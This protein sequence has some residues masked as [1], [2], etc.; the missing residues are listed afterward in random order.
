MFKKSL[1]AALLVLITIV[2]MYFVAVYNNNKTVGVIEKS[3]LT[4]SL[5]RSIVWMHDNESELIK[6]A[7]PML[8]WMINEAYKLN[9]DAR[10]EKLLQAY[11]Q[12]HSMIRT[13]VWGPMFDGR[14]RTFINPSSLKHLPYYNKHLIYSLNCASDLDYEIPIVGE[15]NDSNFCF[16]PSYIYR[17]ACIT[18][19]LM[20]LNFVKQNSCLDVNEID[21]QIAVL[22]SAVINQLTW[23]I[24]VVDV[25]L[26]RVLVLLLIDQAE[27]VKP[28]WLRQVLNAQASDGGWD[29]FD[30]L[31]PL[32]ASSSIGF[33]AKAVSIASN[34]SNLHA[35][36]QG[37]YIMSK[38]IYK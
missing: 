5:E 30:A 10:I 35:T 20:G 14:K 25:Y 13:G 19:Q 26:Q 34:Q 24:R 16:Q 28:V 21:K 32:S 1:Y 31:L 18:H 23:D 22:Q 9:K 2:I 11:H 6:V 3:E 12:K 15:Q 36:A 8:W 33:N 7:S 4:S 38:L 37:L 29:D 17:P 27:Q